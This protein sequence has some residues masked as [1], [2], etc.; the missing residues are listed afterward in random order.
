[1]GHNRASIRK[2][3]GDTTQTGLP[4]PSTVAIMC[5]P[6]KP[7]RNYS[8]NW[9]INPAHILNLYSRMCSVHRTCTVMWGVWDNGLFIVICASH[10]AATCPEY[11]PFH[12]VITQICRRLVNLHC[13][14]MRLQ[15]MD[16]VPVTNFTKAENKG[17]NS[18][19]KPTGSPDPQDRKINLYLVSQWG[20]LHKK[21]KA[22][23]NLY[24]SEA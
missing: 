13:R 15:F 3:R 4:C 6:H 2:G 19:C 17:C 9:E 21:K 20:N 16:K 14:V 22:A 10:D 12:N 11:Q 7:L 1:M 5:F 18:C 8:V 23:T 24:I